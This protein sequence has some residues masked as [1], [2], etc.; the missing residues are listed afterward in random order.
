MRHDLID[1][2]YTY[3]N[4]FASDKEPSGAIKGD[5]VYINLNIYRP[6]PPVLRRPAYPSSPSA[7]EALEKQ[8]QEL[9]QLGVLRKV[10]HNEED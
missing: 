10:G 4:A 5:E 8:I 1:V 6:Y 2:P 3:K 9:I 7:R